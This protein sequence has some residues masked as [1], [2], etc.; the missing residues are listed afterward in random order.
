MVG[1]RFAKALVMK[2]ILIVIL[3]FLFISEISF[4]EIFKW[5]DEKGVVHFTD[6]ILQ[7]PEKYRSEVKKMELPERI[8]ETKAEEEST[9]KNKEEVYNDRLGRGEDYWKARME[10]WR[11]NLKDYQE[12]LETLKDKYNELTVK[13]NDS[14][15]TAERANI[16]GE[17]EQVKIEIDQYK[18]KIQEANNMIDKK[19]PEE[20]ELYK[21]KSEWLR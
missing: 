21:A 19:I 13:I 9:P 15:S 8:E 11:K 14:K 4:A 3:F 7:V 18:I 10:G 1:I 5:V 20:A 6:D 17:R 16:R 12:R 2:R